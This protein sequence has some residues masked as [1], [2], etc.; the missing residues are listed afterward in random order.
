MQQQAPGEVD[1]AWCVI[2]GH[3][4]GPPEIEGIGG[5]RLS[6]KVVCRFCG[7]AIDRSALAIRLAVE[8]VPILQF[9]PDGTR[10]AG[11]EASDLEPELACGIVE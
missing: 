1:G 5:F 11:A 8:K 4:I 10:T 6:L 2:E 3:R 7:G 9:L